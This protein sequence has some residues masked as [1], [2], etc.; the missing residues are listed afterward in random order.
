MQNMRRE[1][2]TAL[3]IHFSLGQQQVIVVGLRLVCNI[4]RH[5]FLTL[6]HF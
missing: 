1:G 4:T 6:G 5:R 2:M 3:Y